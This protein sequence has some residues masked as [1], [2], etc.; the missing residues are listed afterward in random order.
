MIHWRT[1]G[2]EGVIHTRSSIL[3]NLKHACVLWLPKHGLVVGVASYRA[4]FFY[5][6]FMPQCCLHYMY[7]NF[8]FLFFIGTVCIGLF[9][10]FVLDFSPNFFSFHF[11]VLIFHSSSSFYFNLAFLCI[12]FYL[13]FSSTLILDLWDI[14]FMVFFYFLFA[15]FIF[16]SF[17]FLLCLFDVFFLYVFFYF[18]RC[19]PSL[20]F[21]DI[22]LWFYFLGS[23]FRIF[24]F[25]CFSFLL[26]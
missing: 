6:S 2:G 25:L 8:V 19:F 1:R 16:S 5:F 17:L 7:N 24:F 9:L 15:F 23:F 3:D 20:F 26:T 12:S 10:V 13:F 4:S 14:F 21:P 22:F 18:C 11:L